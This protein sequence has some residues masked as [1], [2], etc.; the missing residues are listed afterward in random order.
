MCLKEAFGTQYGVLKEKNIYIR[1][2]RKISPCLLQNKKTSNIPAWAWRQSWGRLHLVQAWWRL[3]A[4]WQWQSERH[5]QLASHLPSCC[6]WEGSL[7]TKD[8]YICTLPYTE[9]HK[10]PW[11][12]IQ[13][14]CDIKKKWKKRFPS[15]HPPGTWLMPQSMTTAPFFTHSPFTISGFPI[16]VTKM[17][18]FP[19]YV[20]KLATGLVL[21]HFFINNNV[22]LG[23]CDTT[24]IVPTWYH[25]AMEGDNVHGLLYNIIYD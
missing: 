12:V 1:L 21:Q 16:P 25:I 22:K 20:A 18:A 4:L 9:A 5:Q 13:C 11:L 8:M 23:L 17:S 7:N 3:L 24:I 6:L 14:C 19:T 2:T 10:H 15:T